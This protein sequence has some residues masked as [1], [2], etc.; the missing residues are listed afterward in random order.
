M[1]KKESLLTPAI[2]SVME[3]MDFRYIFPSSITG[4]LLCTGSQESDPT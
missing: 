3:K 1:P 2:S 4:E